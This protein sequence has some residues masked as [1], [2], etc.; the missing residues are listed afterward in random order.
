[1]N[2]PHSNK[3]LDS[4]R[5]GER[6]CEFSI[7]LAFLG[8][9]LPHSAQSRSFSRDFEIKREDIPMKNVVFLSSFT[10][11]VISSFLVRKLQRQSTQPAS[12][13]LLKAYAYLYTVRTVETIRFLRNSM[14]C[15]IYSVHPLL[16][17][18]IVGVHQSG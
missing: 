4:P 7:V 14:G 2:Y 16:F 9:S 18:T 1:M 6:A 8:S 10:L 11:V 15:T 13:L 17:L 5:G 12:A 3:H